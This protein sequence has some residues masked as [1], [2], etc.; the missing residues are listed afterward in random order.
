MEKQFIGRMKVHLLLHFGSDNL[1]YL[2]A[3]L[4][5]NSRQAWT[6]QHSHLQ[7]AKEMFSS[8]YIFLY[9][10]KYICVLT[11]VMLLGAVYSP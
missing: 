6:V 11:A 9:I 3:H 5:T 2:R 1:T 7:L 8:F 4:K 10:F